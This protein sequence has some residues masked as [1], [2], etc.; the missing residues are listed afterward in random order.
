MNKSNANLSNIQKR[1]NHELALENEIQNLFNFIFYAGVAFCWYH[2]QLCSMKCTIKI[3]IGQNCLNKKP[4]KPQF[5]FLNVNFIQ[6][7]K[8]CQWLIF[9]TKLNKNL[10][11]KIERL[12]TDLMTASNELIVKLGSW[13]RMK[14]IMTSQMLRGY[15]VKNCNKRYQNWAKNLQNKTNFALNLTR[16]SIQVIFCHKCCS[17]LT[18]EVIDVQLEPM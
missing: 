7:T 3:S 6:W 11:S 4:V 14:K 10:A 8:Y 18:W 17:W 2:S 15:K 13:N 16:Y 5:I 12:R 9:L 1:S